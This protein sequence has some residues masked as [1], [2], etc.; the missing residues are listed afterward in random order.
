MNCAIKWEDE[1]KSN[2]QDKEWVSY[3]GIRQDGYH[4]L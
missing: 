3:S 1:I 4:L 2:Q